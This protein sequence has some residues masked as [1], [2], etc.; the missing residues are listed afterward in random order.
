GHGPADGGAGRRAGDRV[1]AITTEQLGP[2]LQEAKGWR[3]TKNRTATVLMW[4]SF[5][6]VIIPLGFVLWTTI[7]KG[8][9]IISWQFLTAPIPPSVL[10]ADVGGVGPAGPRPFLI[11]GLGTLVAGAA[12]VLGRSR[13]PGAGR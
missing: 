9:G 7:A 4:L 11:A 8:I 3:R 12:G 6:L 13:R 10:P 5:V 2:N 1:M